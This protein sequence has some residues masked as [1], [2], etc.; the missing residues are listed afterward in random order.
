MKATNRF[1]FIVAILLFSGI[2]G[3]AQ[4]TSTTSNS[5]TQEMKTYVIERELPNAGKLTADELKAV[6]Q[7]SCS[8]L[9][10]M[11]SDIQWLQSYVTGNK[12]YCVYM[13]KNEDLIKEHAKKG[14]FPCNKI[15]EVGTV[16][17]PATAK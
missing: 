7:K 17:S 4:K 5:K 3:M 10:E 1:S 11:G 9:A 15:S 12:L 13:A 2:A 14:G 6:S 8:V 16:I